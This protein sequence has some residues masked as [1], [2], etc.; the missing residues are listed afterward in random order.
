MSLAFAHPPASGDGISG[1]SLYRYNWL[2]LG[3]FCSLALEFAANI[4]QGHLS[5]DEWSH[6]NPVPTAKAMF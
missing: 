1:D 6:E 2:W 5:N 3:A 4:Y